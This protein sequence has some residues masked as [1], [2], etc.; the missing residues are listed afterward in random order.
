[1]VHLHGSS[2]Y[3]SQSC[4][5]STGN[6]VSAATGHGK[7]AILGGVVRIFMGKGGKRGFGNGHYYVSFFSLV[8]IYLELWC[9]RLF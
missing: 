4:L 9:N 2:A 8:S 1:M 5:I 6:E 3:F 7:D